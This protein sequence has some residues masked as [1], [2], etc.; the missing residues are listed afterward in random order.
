M[1]VSLEMLSQQKAIMEG[2]YLTPRKVVIARLNLR[3]TKSPDL[4]G[5]FPEI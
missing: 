5:D 2:D 1:M 4:S 3:V